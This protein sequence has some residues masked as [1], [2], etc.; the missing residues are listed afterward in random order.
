MSLF[1]DPNFYNFIK[2]ILIKAKVPKNLIPKLLSEV[3]LRRFE[4]AFTHFTFNGNLNYNNELTASIGE[5]EVKD[6]VLKYLRIRLPEVINIGFITRIEH[7]IFKNNWIGEEAKALGFDRFIIH[8][9]PEGKGGYTAIIESIFNSFIGCLADIIDSQYI[10][11]TSGVIIYH[12]IK[13]MLDKREFSLNIAQWWDSISLLNEMYKS[14][15]WSSG[16]LVTDKNNTKVYAY[17]NSGRLISGEDSKYKKLIADVTAD[18][19][20]DFKAATEA[21]KYLKEHYSFTF[22]EKNPYSSAG[23]YQMKLMK[24]KKVIE[25]EEEEGEEDKIDNHEVKKVSETKEMSESKYFAQSILDQAIKF[26]YDYYKNIKIVDSSNFSCLMPWQIKSVQSFFKRLFP[27]PSFIIDGTSNI[28][29]DILNFRRM[30]PESFIIGME[31]DKETFEALKDNVSNDSNIEVFH[32]SFLDFLDN[33]TM[34]PNL[35]SFIY[36]DPPWSTGLKLDNI[37]I[38]KIVQK[39]LDKN[40]KVVLKLPVYF[41]LR[42]DL[43][44]IV[45]DYDVVPTNAKKATYRLLYIK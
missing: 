2:N 1:K 7:T 14:K 45:E 43:K 29:C 30:Y 41:T 10:T 5:L 31:I 35:I 16:N 38:D 9:I 28:G 13:D 12:I 32:R 24:G 34:D 15:K 44:R 42:L 3:N 27:D 8:A 36:L 11:G 37:P 18:V 19:H 20:S 4:S 40:I 6:S 39:I 22:Q 21:I 17:I 23:K 26:G 33:M 25:E